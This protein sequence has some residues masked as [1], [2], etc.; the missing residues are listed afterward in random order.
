MSNLKVIHRTRMRDQPSSAAAAVRTL[1]VGTDLSPSGTKQTET[2]AG[3]A[4]Q[5]W[6]QATFVNP[7]ANVSDTGWVLSSD[8]QDTA[9]VRPP[10]DQGGF[11]R[12]SIMAERT[13]NNVA[14]TAP[15]LVSANFIIARALIETG[16]TNAEPKIAGSDA[17]G[18]LQ[19][20]TAEWAMLL[21]SGTVYGNFSALERDSAITQ[22]Y[23]AAFRMHSDAQ[24]ISD[25]LRT[26]PANPVGTQ[27]DPFIPSLADVFNAYLTGS[28]GAAAA[29]LDA[30]KDATGQAKPL[31][32]VLA[33]SLTDPQ[34]AA[35]FAARSKY[36][37]TIEQPKTVGAFVAAVEADLNDALKKAF[38]LMQ[39]HAPDELVQV[40]QGEAPWFD[41]A[42]EEEKKNIDE[43]DP[44]QKDTILHYFD[45]TDLTPKPTSTS[46]PWCGAFAAHC[47]AE[48]GYP[49]PKGAAAAKN[50]KGWGVE[51]PPGS[52]DIPRGAVIVLSPSEGTGSTG[53]VGFF[54]QM[55]ENGTKVELL[56]GNQSD[57]LKRT[58]FMTSKIAS[59]RWIDSAPT[60]SKA[61]FGET[62]SPSKISKAAFD[63]IVESEVSSKALYE[64]RF[65]GPTWPGFQSGVTIGIGYDVGQTGATELQN[66]WN[67]VIPD[68][69][70]AALRSAVGITGPAARERTQQLKGQVDVP[71]D[72]AIKVHSDRV[73]PRWVAIVEKALGPNTSL[74][75]PDCLGALVSLTYN[76]GPSFSKAGDRY[77]EMRAIKEC[78]ANKKF[79]EIPAQF[80][81]MK[82]LWPSTSGLPPR[83]EQEARLFEQGLAEV[84]GV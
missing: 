46:T 49:V 44:A 47:M 43:H 21:G 8:V 80:R 55:L 42:L 52:A 66:D 30:N 77:T 65:R 36:T 10:V 70:L 40:K 37:G 11:V 41:V 26:R 23:G 54:N 1:E 82:R 15:W 69:M 27:A 50:W 61:Q 31:N 19:V 35:F 28:P 16:I 59:I 38:E 29:I 14:A 6:Q 53:H 3:G 83:R 74:L 84:K 33:P 39:E 48:S 75:S 57:K 22:I 7:G 25:A 58:A 18:P 4:T 13:F 78:V 72:A 67:S 12:E 34:I 68:P 9:A 45:A 81:S 24:A 5:E 73:I 20:S 64:K 60:T 63:L 2:L 56:G 32:A 62:P 79:S 17:V 71:F 76:R 51:L